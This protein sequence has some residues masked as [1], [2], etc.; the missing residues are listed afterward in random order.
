MAATRWA[1]AR[2]QILQG[3]MPQPVHAATLQ[4]ADQL[5]RMVWGQRP[6]FALERIRRLTS[7]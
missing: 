6:S 1:K 5:L 4:Q 7:E 3:Q 2:S